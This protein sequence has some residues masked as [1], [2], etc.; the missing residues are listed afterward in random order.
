MAQQAQA[1]PTSGGENAKTV[2]AA[3]GLTLVVGLICTQLEINAYLTEALTAGAGAVP[4]A[5]G[6]AAHRRRATAAAG[7][8]A[9]QRR[10]SPALVM[11]LTAAALVAVDSALG[12]YSFST[13]DPGVISSVGYL[14]MGI[15]AAG[16]AIASKWFMP[17]PYRWTLTTVGLVFVFR[18]VIVFL[19]DP[20]LL[21]L[22]FVDLL[23]VYA[24]VAA[25][26]AVATLIA[27][28]LRSQPAGQAAA[29]TMQPTAHA[30][31]TQPT[32]PP[33]VPMATQAPPTV[34]MPVPMPA[35]ATPPVA[36]PP[37]PQPA[38][39]P[40]G[41]YPDPELRGIIRY[42]DGTRW[43]EHRRNT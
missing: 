21:D 35:P 3:A 7:T 8:Q 23:E 27:V 2:A 34:P 19:Y 14:S 26:T 4:A 28:K 17:N 29:T 33:T 25:A 16:I 11:I 38:G 32:A 41:W 18:L 13:E 42:W 22:V 9:G 5:W 10:L 31:P 30:V 43:T 36:V 20:R 1:A 15:M 12:A 24:K 39:P 6:V 37:P 40:A